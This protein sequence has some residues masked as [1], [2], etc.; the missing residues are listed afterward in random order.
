MAM[1]YI[2]EIRA[3]YDSLEINSLSA[4]AINLWHALMHIANKAQ[5]KDSF[6]VAI[7]TLELKTGLKKKAI[8]NA[9]NLLCQKGCIVCTKGNGSSSAT[10]SMISRLNNP[11][12]CLSDTQTGTQSGTH[13][14]TRLGTQGGTHTGTINKQNKTKLNT[15]SNECVA[16][17][18]VN[19][20]KYGKYGHVF[21]IDAEFQK[22]KTFGRQKER[23]NLSLLLLFT[24]EF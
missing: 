4:Q 20:S 23:I 8:I 17:T 19:K 14:G 1:N 15:H 7:A 5:W 24:T 3:F 11:I 10:Y 12:V 22:L 18:R 9:R 2:L 6:S 16:R 21:L 13:I